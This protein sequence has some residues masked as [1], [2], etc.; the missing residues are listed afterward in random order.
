MP[1][2]KFIPKIIDRREIM[3]AA[4]EHHQTR[5]D[6]CRRAIEHINMTLAFCDETQA[7]KNI[8]RRYTLHSRPYK[9]G[10]VS[11]LAMDALRDANS[12]LTARE[13]LEIVSTSL[14]ANRSQKA[15]RRLANNVRSVLVGKIQHG[16]V[17]SSKTPGEVQ[18]YQIARMHLKAP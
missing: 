18:T 3:K 15:L 11:S 8:T 14:R 4:L 2:H 6:F 10:I 9:H 13:I 7:A 1:S 16:L 17:V 12:P 5:A